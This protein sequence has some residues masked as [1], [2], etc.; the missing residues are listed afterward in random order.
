MPGGGVREWRRVRRAK[1]AREREI[2]IDI[3][4][5]FLLVGQAA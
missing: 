1:R 5:S 3:I 4:S 2:S